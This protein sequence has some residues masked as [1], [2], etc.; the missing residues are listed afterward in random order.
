MTVMRVAI[1]G[2]GVAGL[3]CAERLDSLG[4][5]TQLFDK[6]KRP[7]GRLSTLV[8]DDFAWDFSKFLNQPMIVYSTQLVNHHVARFLHFCGSFFNVNPQNLT[9]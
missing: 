4:A 1:I 5:T 7:G 2:A 6:G 9:F 3:A 8:L